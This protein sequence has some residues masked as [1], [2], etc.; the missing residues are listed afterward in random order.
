MRMRTVFVVMNVIGVLMVA[1]A[2]LAQV[3]ESLFGT[4]KL[5]L[6]KSKYSP[7]PAPKS[8]TV[9]WEAF[10]GG[11]KLTVDTV[12][13]KG[14]ALHWESSGKFDGKDNP[15]KGD[16]DNDTAAFSKIDARTYQTVQKKGGKATITS[17]IVVA[18]DGKTRITTQTGT[19]AKVAAVS[20]TQFYDKQ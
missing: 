15:L 6:A 20:N 9:R 1:V 5:N 4:W 17:H 10:Q 13:V 8:S 14:P 7:G 18:A 19:D 2:L 3:Q 11:A 16:P 12:P